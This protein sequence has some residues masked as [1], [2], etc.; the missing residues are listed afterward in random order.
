MKYLLLETCVK[1]PV[2]QA[3]TSDGSTCIGEFSL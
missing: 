2:P 3:L 1:T